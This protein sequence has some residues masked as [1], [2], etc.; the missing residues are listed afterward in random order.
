MASSVLVTPM[1]EKA[2]FDIPN[3]RPPFPTPSRVCAATYGTTRI[4]HASHNEADMVKIP[5]P[6]VA[7]F[8]DSLCY[9]A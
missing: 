9:A 7:R 5:R 4:F 2:W 3:R 8:I 6:L 1:P